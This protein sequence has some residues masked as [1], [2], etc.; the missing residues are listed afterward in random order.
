MFSTRKKKTKKATNLNLLK[1]IENVFNE[2]VGNTVMLNISH[3]IKL[4]PEN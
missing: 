4:T 3:Q 1:E 2:T